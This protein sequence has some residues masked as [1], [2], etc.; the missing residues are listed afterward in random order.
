[1]FVFRELSREEQLDT[2]P[3]LTHFAADE[4]EAKLFASGTQERYVLLVEAAEDETCAREHHL[5][6]AGHILEQNI[7]RDVRQDEVVAFASS[8]REASPQSISSMVT[9]E[10]VAFSCTL[11]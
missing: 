1:M 8:S 6:V 3:A 10:S 2:A 5:A 9:P 7:A 11:A 4:G